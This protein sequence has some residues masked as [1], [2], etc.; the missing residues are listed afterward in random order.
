MSPQKAQ[1]WGKAESGLG[2]QHEAVSLHLH[3]GQYLFQAVGSCIMGTPCQTSSTH[4]QTC[5]TFQQNSRTHRH[6]QNRAGGLYMLP[7]GANRKWF[8]INDFYIISFDS[9]ICWHILVGQAK[10]ESSYHPATVLKPM[11]ASRGRFRDTSEAYV[12]A[13]W[14]IPWIQGV[15]SLNMTFPLR[16]C[17]ETLR[18]SLF[19]LFKSCLPSKLLSYLF[20]ISSVW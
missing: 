2:R 20:F 16:G 6:G 5:Q 12:Q 1:S 14:C 7:P 8:A 15:L 4:G 19:S 11:V 18:I 13:T 17:L 3:F 10:T 9:F